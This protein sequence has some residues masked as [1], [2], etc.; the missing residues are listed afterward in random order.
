MPQHADARSQVDARAVLVCRIDPGSDRNRADLR[1]LRDPDGDRERDLL[2]LGVQL[3]GAPQRRVEA[4]VAG[5]AP[6]SEAAQHQHVGSGG[7]AAREIDRRALPDRAS[8]GECPGPPDGLAPALAAHV[9]GDRDPAGQLERSLEAGPGD[10]R[11]R[12]GLGGRHAG[13]GRRARR[14]RRGRDGPD[15]DRDR[16]LRPWGTDHR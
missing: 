9:D 15:R 12:R 11:R 2:P 4:R 5:V 13:A 1:R 3:A 7:A 16:Q 6:R 8:R 14:D 10:L